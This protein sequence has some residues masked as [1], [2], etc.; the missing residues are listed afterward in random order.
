MHYIALNCTLTIGRE[1][2]MV[3]EDKKLRNAVTDHIEEMTDHNQGMTDLELV[4]VGQL[5]IS[6]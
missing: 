4:L 6:T 2:K 5:H 3:W 1:I